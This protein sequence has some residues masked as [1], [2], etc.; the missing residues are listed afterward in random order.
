MTP[1]V[2]QCGRTGGDTRRSSVSLS[3]PRW[4]RGVR[5][6]HTYQQRLSRRSIL[7]SDR[8]N[9]TP[10]SSPPEPR[11]RSLEQTV[12][13]RSP[14]RLRPVRTRLPPP[15]SP[16]LTFSPMKPPTQLQSLS[17]AFILK[18]LSDPDTG[19]SRAGTLTDCVQEFWVGTRP[20]LLRRSDSAVPGSNGSP[21]R[22]EPEPRNN[23]H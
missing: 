7:T 14:V 18:Y 15:P 1:P 20:C 2:L 19:G 3:V 12:S 21:L 6:P 17:A 13:W 10:S 16:L 23:P 5:L 4:S 8:Q 11:C 22:R 9:R